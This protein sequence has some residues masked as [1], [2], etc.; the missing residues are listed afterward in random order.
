LQLLDVAQ[1]D[2]TGVNGESPTNDKWLGTKKMGL[3]RTYD[4]WKNP[5]TIGDDFSLPNV[6]GGNIRY[7]L[8]SMEQE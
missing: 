3:G 8:C 4:I 7:S 2:K 6:P 1:L 5:R